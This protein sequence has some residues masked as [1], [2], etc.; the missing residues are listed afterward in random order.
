MLV[1]NIV[2][3]LGKSVDL[4]PFWC[5]AT[6]NVIYFDFMMSLSKT[7]KIKFEDEGRV[8]QEEWKDMFLKRV[9]R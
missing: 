8:F 7:K 9:V 1:R 5:C 6:Y 4:L 2:C 3:P